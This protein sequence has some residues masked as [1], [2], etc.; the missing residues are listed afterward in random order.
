MALSKR[1][2]S[3]A[4]AFFDHATEHAEFCSRVGLVPVTHDFQEAG[5]GVLHAHSEARQFLLRGAQRGDIFTLQRLMTDRARRGDAKG[6]GTNRLLDDLPHLGD[7]TLVC[8]LVADGAL[9]HYIDANGGMRQ[10]GAEVDVALAAFQRGQEFAEAFPLPLQAFGHDG[11][12]D[13]FNALHQLNQLAAVFWSARGEADATI[14][15]D[16]CGDAV[17]GGG[18]HPAVP[19]GLGVVMG[20]DVD[21]AGGHQLA[22][23]VDLFRATRRYLADFDNFA[24]SDGDVGFVRCGAGAVDN[25]AIANDDA[26]FFGHDP[27]PLV[28]GRKS[29]SDRLWRQNRR[30]SWIG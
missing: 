19:S 13:V 28:F 7:I 26:D 24:T 27:V 9:T 30:V 20:M 11:P 29:R 10:Q 15:H 18:S 3:V 8:G 17:P 5:A 14:A 25:G 22:L 12:R 23:R 16:G 4:T 6:A 21:E 2:H 1:E